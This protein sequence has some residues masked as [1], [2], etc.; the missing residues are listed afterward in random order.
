MVF[1]STGFNYN[2]LPLSKERVEKNSNS[3]FIFPKNLIQVGY[4]T[5]HFSYAANNFVSE[6]KIPIF[7]GGDAEVEK[8]VSLHYQR[9]IFHGRKLFSLDWG[10]S[11]SF[12]KSK[13]KNDQFY[14]FSVFP[15]F[16]FTF[17]R[18]R[19]A[20][21]YF[22]YSV[23]GPTFISK[24]TIDSVNTGKHFTFQDLMGIGTFA[25][26]NRHINAEVRIGHYS[27]GNIF[28]NNDGVKIPLTFNLGYSF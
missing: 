26:K 11:L 12:W 10:T 3:G 19:P 17:L 1:Y 24:T 28:P 2:M 22:Y 8:G 7:W 15:L 23:A 9:N 21:L 18:T 25:G 6:G 4:S 5:N 13:N 20:D 27:N 16:R 14:T